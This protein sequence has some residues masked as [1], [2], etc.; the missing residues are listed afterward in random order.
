MIELFPRSFVLDETSLYIAIR[1]CRS[2]TITVITGDRWQKLSFSLWL[3]Y[4]QAELSKALLHS[5]LLKERQNNHKL[6]SSVKMF[7]PLWSS[8]LKFYT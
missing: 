1:V 3:S 4:T 7:H 8:K 2:S 5:K 6:Q